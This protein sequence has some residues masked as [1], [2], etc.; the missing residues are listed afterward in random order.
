MNLLVSGAFFMILKICV[1]YYITYFLLTDIKHLNSYG[2]FP[3]LLTSPKL[4]MLRAKLS[5]F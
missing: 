4:N 3:K 1:I 5:V 2:C